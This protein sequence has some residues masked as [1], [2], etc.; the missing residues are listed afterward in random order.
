MTTVNLF[1]NSGNYK[2]ETASMIL[3]FSGS[4]SFSNSQVALS[5]MSMYNQW[6]NISSDYENH[7]IQILYPVFTAANTY[8]MQT[9]TL[10]LQAGYYNLSEDF[11]RAIGLFCIQNGLYLVDGSG[12]TVMFQ[13]LIINETAYACEY[14][15]YYLP[16]ASQ[17]AT[18][19][20]TNPSG[21][22]L[23]TGTMQVA[24][25]IIIT[26]GLA[27]Y[28][29]IVAGTYPATVL[30]STATTWSNTA[31]GTYRGTL[32][33]EVNKVTAIQ[34][35][36]GDAFVNS[37]IAQ[38]YNALVQVPVNA[39]YGGLARYE[40]A[41]PLYMPISDKPRT[42]VELEFWDQAGRRLRPKDGEISMVLSIRPLK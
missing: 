27:K 1:L 39:A 20:W 3:P 23:N 9:Y 7:I 16:T 30:T 19:G 40:P 35:R 6:A 29:G 28:T 32:A 26:A 4:T 33:P 5:S 36:M 13:K 10:T 18:M 22:V 17:A 15:S 41:N 12:N 8:T 2:S 34:V 24:P 25:R 11:D 42:Q 38:P 31:A 37:N 21:R 14:F